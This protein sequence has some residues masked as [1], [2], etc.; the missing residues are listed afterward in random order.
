MKK[1]VV[2][3]NSLTQGQYSGK[4]GQTISVPSQL[5]DE[6]IK[7]GWAKLAKE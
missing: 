2:L 1:I 7:L 6:W 5:A 4:K 3:R